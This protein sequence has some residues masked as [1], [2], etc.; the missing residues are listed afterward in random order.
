MNPSLQKARDRRIDQ[1]LEA[2]NQHE[3]ELV[4]VDFS[5]GAS[6]DDLAWNDHAEGQDGIRE[7]Y[8]ELYAAAPDLR[9]EEIGRSEQGDRVTVDCL[10]HGTHKGTWHGVHPTGTSF[11]VPAQV[12]YEFGHGSEF[13]HRE[14]VAYE[15]MR[16]MEQFGV[17][18]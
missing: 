4:V 3:L 11:H 16:L 10:L 9:I 15:R 8:R 1:H 5:E 2:E 13:L 18:H 17:Q 7:W 14:T 12:T 6:C